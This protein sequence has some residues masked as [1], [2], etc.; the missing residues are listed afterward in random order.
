LKE[1]I[2]AEMVTE[3]AASPETFSRRIMP[4]PALAALFLMVAVWTSGALAETPRTGGDSFLRDEYLVLGD[5]ASGSWRSLG[6]RTGLA[7]DQIGGD[8]LG[9]EF[10]GGSVRREDQDEEAVQGPSNTGDKVK[11]GLLS[12]VLPGAGQF[13]NGQKSKAY[14]M[15]GVEAAIWTAYFVF[16]AQG[17]AR[18]ESAE[19][20]AGIYAGTS[21]EHQNSYWQN[22]GHYMDSDA[23]NESRLREARALEETVTGLIG[24]ID[25]WQWV[26]EDRKDEYSQL[27][28]DGN[29]AYDR[30]DFMILFAV[31]NRT[32]SVVD[33]VL[34]AGKQDGL[35]E[36]EVLGMN[37]EL[38]MLP[39][40]SD[41]GARWVVSRRF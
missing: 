6:A 30:R 39:S 40:F 34:N 31:V 22:V 12:A 32:V 28:A 23:Y 38:E 10:G 2:G 33:A 19:E 15:V 35:L 1:F 9:D 13:Y 5:G 3:P 41:P 20:W 26:N 27:R 36:T 25:A 21:G 16:D 37:V 4:A 11:A 7:F 29:S 14:I 17:D 24:G 18:M 8:G